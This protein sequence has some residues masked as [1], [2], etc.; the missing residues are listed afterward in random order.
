VTSTVVIQSKQGIG[1]VIWHL[2][3]MR[4]IAAASPGGKVLFLALPS[5]CARELLQAEPCVERTIYFENRGSELRRIAHQM[6][7]IRTLR[8]L[9][10]DTAWMLDVRVRP[11]KAGDRH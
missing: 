1:D 9:N 2:P 8:G 10:C 6:R 5:T 4:A 3:Y 7:F 11:A